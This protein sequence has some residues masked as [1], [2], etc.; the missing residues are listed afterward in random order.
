MALSSLRWLVTASLFSISCPLV[1]GEYDEDIVRP[2]EPAMANIVPFQTL[3]DI[4]DIMIKESIEKHGFCACPYSTDALGGQCGSLSAYYHPWHSILC[5]RR[6]ITNNMAYFYRLQHAL[7]AY[8]AQQE[9]L[10]AEQE[11][12]DA[13]QKAAKEA[14]EAKK[15]S[16]FTAD[17]FRNSA[18]PLPNTITLPSNVPIPPQNVSQDTGLTNNYFKSNVPLTPASSSPSLPNIITPPTP[19]TQTYTTQSY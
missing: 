8:Q 6:D 7:N 5:Y 15:R 17:Y 11:A 3:N 1:A 10:D 2:H 12:A 13:E 18:K 19:A 9:R 16:E 4:R 14:L